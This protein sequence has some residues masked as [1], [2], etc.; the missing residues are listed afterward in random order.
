MKPKKHDEYG[1]GLGYLIKQGLNNYSNYGEYVP[2]PSMDNDGGCRYG[3]C[4][5][6]GASWTEESS[7]FWLRGNTCA[8]GSGHGEGTATGRGDEDGY[9]Y[10][11]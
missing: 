11:S 4:T 2:E 9:G 1:R 10:E 6:R 7:A 3:D 5:K 8:H